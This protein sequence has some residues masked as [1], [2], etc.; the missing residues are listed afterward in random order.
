MKIILEKY[1]IQVLFLVLFVGILVLLNPRGGFALNDDWVH[2]L[3]IF[4]WVEM[5]NWYY[6]HYL[7]AYNVVP[8]FYGIAVS[9]IFGFSFTVLRLTNIIIT[10]ASVAVFYGILRNHKINEWLSFA[11]SILLLINPLII[12][13]AYSFMGDA[14]TMFFLVT[15]AYFYDRS[16]TSLQP[17]WAVWG[18]LMLLL[19]YFTRQ[20]AAVFYVAVLIQGLWYWRDRKMV[21]A[22]V[23]PGVL[24]LAVYA[25]LKYFDVSPGQAEGHVVEW[26]RTYFMHLSYTLWDYVLLLSL[27]GSPVTLA[28]ISK[29]ASWL[30]R[31]T[32]WLPVIFMFLMFIIMRM[33]GHDFPTNNVMNFYGLGPVL[34]VLQGNPGVTWGTPLAYSILQAV[35]AVVSGINFY[36]LAHWWR[37]YRF[38]FDYKTAFVLFYL[39][40]ITMIYSFDRYLV[41]ILPFWLLA[42]AIFAVRYN[43]RL[44]V[45]MLGGGVIALYSLIGTYN[46]LSWNQVRWQIGD[47]LVSQGVPLRGIENGYEWNG[48]H[49]YYGSYGQPIGTTT[50]K[51]A[52]W[53]V[54]N[55]FEGHSMDYIISFSPIDTYQVVWRQSVPGVL[56]NIKYLY[57]NKKAK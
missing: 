22:V 9:K 38:A 34:P 14:S 10:F 40:L 54:K 3:S 57:V 53:Y 30:K 16:F 28:I 31:P 47:V 43:Y 11:V 25:L 20:V 4:N 8:I 24:G 17:K 23:M 37:Y 55:L 2:A 1:K 49:I 33:R 45:A 21:L 46:Y 48:W 26:G 51:W 52:P 29:N 19:A 35:A 7:A 5:K 56:S 50:P 42:L 15:A 13:L 36:I 18:G 32:F 12:N 39:L 44:W 41:L 6:S 27:F